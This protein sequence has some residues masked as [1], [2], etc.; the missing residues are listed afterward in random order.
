LKVVAAE[1]EQL[2]RRYLIAANRLEWNAFRAQSANYRTNLPT[3][4]LIERFAAGISFFIKHMY[5]SENSTRVTLDSGPLRTH[6]RTLVRRTA[7][8][9]IGDNCH[10]DRLTQ[11]E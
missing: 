8:E 5:I 10:Q 3:L 4:D 6:P 7:Q 11:I 1:I 9:Y 2:T